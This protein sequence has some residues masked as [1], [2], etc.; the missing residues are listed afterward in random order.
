[1]G[2]TV[3]RNRK[4]YRDYDIEEEYEAGMVLQ[5]TE[6]KSLRAGRC[7]IKEGYAKIERGEVFLHNVHIAKYEQGNRENH[8]PR[9]KRKLLL[10]QREI[11][12]LIGKTSQKGYTLVP[13]ELYFKNGY[14]KIKLGL[15]KGRAK[16]DKRQKIKERDEKR[17]MDKQLKE[18]ERNRG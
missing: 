17:R 18:Y 12:R 10:K 1:M 16:H 13:L 3:A 11:N 5:G 4:A 7:S 6:V 8:E 2:K 9:R 14:A 15:G